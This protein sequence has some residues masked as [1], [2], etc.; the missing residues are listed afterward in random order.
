M[1]YHT[2]SHSP[3]LS[4]L[5]FSQRHLFLLVA[6]FI[7]FFSCPEPPGYPALSTDFALFFRRPVLSE[8]SQSHPAC[9]LWSPPDFLKT[10]LSF[11]CVQPSLS[12]PG[13]VQLSSVWLSP[14][15]ALLLQTARL[16]LPEKWCPVTLSFFTSQPAFCLMGVVSVFLR[17][18]CRPSRRPRSSTQTC[19]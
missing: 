6:C 18:W 12:S 19:Q 17:S 9:H 7:I 4:F 5:Y 10:A 13:W 16:N 2:A 11:P 14:P 15:S 1:A 3:F 8:S